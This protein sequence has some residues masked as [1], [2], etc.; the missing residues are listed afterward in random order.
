MKTISATRF[1]ATCFALLDAVGPEGII[2]TRRGKPVA[3]LLPAR[4]NDGDLIGILRD[5]EIRVD[6]NDDLFSTGAWVS[7]EWGDANG[8]RVPYRPVQGGVEES[9]R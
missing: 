1:R 4:T 9:R 3:K 8:G 2:I 5:V 6:P 7:E